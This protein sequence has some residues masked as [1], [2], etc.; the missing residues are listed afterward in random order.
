MNQKT[1]DKIIPTFEGKHDTQW[2]TQNTIKT[3]KKQQATSKK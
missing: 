2:E 3:E 1:R